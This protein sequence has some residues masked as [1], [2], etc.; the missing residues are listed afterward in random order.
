MP[1]AAEAK[2]MAKKVFS[3]EGD[4]NDAEREDDLEYDVGNLACFDAH[5][6]DSAKMK[7]K[8]AKREK[9]LRKTATKNVQLL[10]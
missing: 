10:L 3:G 9:Y 6:L 4:A 5:P 7:L 8:L 2:R 1:S